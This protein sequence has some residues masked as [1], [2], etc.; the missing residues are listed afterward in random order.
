MSTQQPAFEFVNM[1]TGERLRIW[2]DGRTEGM[3]A[4]AGWVMINRIPQLL[5]EA[6]QRAVQVG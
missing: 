2:A 4:Y 3:E 1:Q 5:A 6:A